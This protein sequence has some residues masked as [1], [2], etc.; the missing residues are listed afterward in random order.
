MIGL[1]IPGLPTAGSLSGLAVFHNT[2][3]ILMGESAQ[4]MVDVTAMF[5]P[6]SMLTIH[7]EDPISFQA[8]TLE[9]SFVDIGDQIIKSKQVKKGIWIKVKI[10]QWN[11]DYPSSHVQRDLGSFQ[12]D[13]IKTQWPP[14]QVTFMAS[15]VPI[16]EQIK[17]TLQNKT[18]F[19]LTLKD[20]GQ[21]V[22]DENH[23][24]YVWDVP[25]DGRANYRV[26]SQAQQW[27]ESDLQMLSRY[28]RQNALSMKIKD[29]NGKQSIVVFD[30]QELEKKPPVY[31]IDFSQPGAGIGLVHGELTTQSQDIYS[32]SQLA[33]YDS[34]ANTLYV[35]KA[36]APPDTADGSKETLNVKDLKSAQP[37][38]SGED[39]ATE[40]D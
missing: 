14:T 31:T 26:M 6:M 25:A 27:N 29:V 40:G 10:D 36:D 8:D 38:G 4:S 5:P 3:Q 13:Q 24:G 9:L 35:G 39:I 16:S 1:S 30:E 17:L 28:L 20:L 2:I 18:R 37:G 22:A 21:Q 11:R 34:N 32:G 12:L 23:L 19:A 15:S 7:Y 33:Y